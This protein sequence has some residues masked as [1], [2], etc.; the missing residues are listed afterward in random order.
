MELLKAAGYWH[1]PIF[2]KEFLGDYVSAPFSRFHHETFNCIE[3]GERGVKR[4]VVAP[5]GVGKSTCMVVVYPLH[6]ICYM[7]F[8]ELL[9]FTPDTFI[10]ILSKSET[11]AKSRVQSIKAEIEYNDVLREA[12]GDLRGAVWGEKRLVTSNGVQVVPLGRGGQVRGSLFRHVRPSLII[13]DDLDDPETVE[14]PD[15]RMKDQKWFDTDLMR[16][17]ALDQSTNFINVDTI[18]HEEAT[19]SL[20]RQRSG[21]QTLFFQA[22]EHPA[23]LWHPTAEDTWKEWEAIYTDQTLPDTERIVKAQAF[24]DAH[25]DAMMHGVR[26]LWEPVISYLDVRKEV[27]DMGYWAV[28]RELQNSTRDPS[29][30]IFDMDNAV[31]FSIKED[32]LLRSDERLVRWNQF[33]G[34][35]VFLDWAG[36]KDSQDNAFACAV[37][38]LWEPLPGRRENTSS[39]SGA[40]GYVWKVWMD[41]VKL[42]V[43]IENAL[44]LMLDIQSHLSTRDVTDLKWRF[45]VEDFV[46][47]ADTLRDYVQVSFKEAEERKRSGVRL[48]FTKRF[49]NKVERIAALEPA[50]THGWLGFNERLP[51]DYVKQ[52]SLFPTADFMDGPDA[53]EGACQ[54]RVTEFQSVRQ[55]R[56]ARSRKL[57]REFGVQ[58]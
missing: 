47:S 53:T 43:Q 52:M 50:I 15:V 9:G 36:G 55:D 38:V 44:D 24:F 18:K 37:C 31:R 49:T 23:D 3:R 13:S 5:R 51:V 29:R 39:F 1:I 7:S 4:N 12:F 58:L 11:M 41:R 48:E 33:S 20:L 42:S 57:Q 10:L 45:S 54:L 27:A 35:S 26:H 46:E 34:A 14:N 25:R 28:L 16:A 19:A 40:Y 21:W 8:D 22:I 56:R 2:M 30:A 17:G 6:R 32:G